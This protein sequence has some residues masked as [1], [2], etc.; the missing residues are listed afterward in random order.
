MRALLH[1]RE[2][3][4]GE[5][6][7]QHLKILK[8][9]ERLS[10]NDLQKLQIDKLVKLLDYLKVN[11]PYY[12]KYFKDN[13]L[14]FD[15]YV[16]KSPYSL[17]SHF[18][19]TEKAFIKEHF[20]E[21]L[22]SN[23]DYSKLSVQYTSGSTGTPF[24]FYSTTMYNDIKIACKARLLDWHGV[25]RGEKQFCYLGVQ[26]PKSA[27]TRI[28]ILVNNRFVWNQRIISSTSLSPDNEIIA[29]NKQDP[30]TIYGYPSAIAEIA[31]QL[32]EKNHDFKV[33]RFK[34]VI[35]S[36]ESHTAQMKDLIR[37]A[38]RCEPVDEYCT[39]EGFIAGTCEFN[40]L[41]I[42]EDTLIAEVLNKNGE[43]TEYGK[44]ELLVTYL[45]SFDFPFVRYRTGDIVDISGE[46]CQC[47]R[48]FKILKSVDGRSGSYI[49]NGTDKIYIGRSFIPMQYINSVIS[50]Q[51]IQNELSSV[52]VRLVVISKSLNLKPFED[53]IRKWFDKLNVIFEYVD[54]LQREDSGKIRVVINNIKSDN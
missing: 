40:K 45:N 28:K 27:I 46:K 35:F 24:K 3:I 9:S 8:Q 33:K 43:I 37:N 39:M 2:V 7:S 32:I 49:Y 10:V 29:L 6:V 19:V 53:Y 47:I 16:I 41:H 4:K 52:L 51:L 5:R 18:P 42:N 38:F 20:E 25:R 30:V 12:S 11:N 26:T 13:N 14:S 44:G 22:T 34:K 31:K 15:E 54:S 36:G 23:I 21:W 1:L 50:F 48:S 17:L